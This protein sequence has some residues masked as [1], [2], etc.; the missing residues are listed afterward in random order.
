M[1]SFSFLFAVKTEALSSTFTAIV[2]YRQMFSTP[3]C[4]RQNVNDDIL[5]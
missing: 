3:S 2:M 4:C 5:S 1:F